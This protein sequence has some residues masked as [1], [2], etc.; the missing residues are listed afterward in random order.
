[1]SL[2]KT[3]I[4][5]PPADLARAAELT[6]LVSLDLV[7]RDPQARMLLGYRNNRPAQGSWF[8]PGGRIGK[9]ERLTAAFDRISRGEL[10][11]PLAM[12][13][14]RSL[15][16]FEHLYD[17]NFAGIPGFGTHYI[18]L[19]YTLTVDPSR[20]TLPQDQHSRYL[21]LGDDEI[22]GRDDVHAYSRAYCGR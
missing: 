18:V 16:V 20:L 7:I 2:E 10:G 19:A 3:P 17:D 12:T 1:M 4:W 14:A 8:V 9:N 5:L 13:E 6:P 15:G 22:L 11:T 21:W